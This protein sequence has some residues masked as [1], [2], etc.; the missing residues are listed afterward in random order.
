MD[1]CCNERAARTR[2][3]LAKTIVVMN[4]YAVNTLIILLGTIS[5]GIKDGRLTEF[6]TQEILRARLHSS[7]DSISRG[8]RNEMRLSP[9]IVGRRIST[10]RH[11]LPSSTWFGTIVMAMSGYSV[12]R[13][14]SNFSRRL[15]L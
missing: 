7:A 9:H 5:R 1:L 2:R 10:M 3:Y 15:I 6:F 11:P 8:S 4:S 12:G 14:I 13:Y